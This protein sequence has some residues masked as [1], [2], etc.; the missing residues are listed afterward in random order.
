MQRETSL[1]MI[2]FSQARQSLGYNKFMRFWNEFESVL[3]CFKALKFNQKV[4]LL[5][6]D[7][8]NTKLK[9]VIN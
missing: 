8:K 2:F 9:S 1:G 5:F 7:K 6:F 3:S 4:R